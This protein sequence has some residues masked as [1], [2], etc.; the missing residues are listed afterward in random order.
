MPLVIAC[1]WPR[2]VRLVHEE[3]LQHVAD[4]VALHT[5]LAARESDDGVECG[6]VERLTAG[7]Q[8]LVARALARGQGR[9]VVE[10]DEVAPGAL[11][12]GVAAER[13][14]EARKEARARSVK[15]FARE[16]RQCR[17][18]AMVCEP[19][20]A[21]RDAHERDC[22]HAGGSPSAVCRR[23]G[24]REVGAHGAPDQR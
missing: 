6:D 11:R 7:D 15:L 23:A 18:Q 24:L 22:V 1:A 10:G 4:A 14:E 8:P 3:V 21:R 17:V 12:I 13:G 5:A 19:V 16:W 9:K 20:G 2:L